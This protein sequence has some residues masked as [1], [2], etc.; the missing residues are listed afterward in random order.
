MHPLNSIDLVQIFTFKFMSIFKKK[1]KTIRFPSRT[2]KKTVESV[3]KNVIV[4]MGSS[5]LPKECEKSTVEGNSFFSH[6]HPS[7]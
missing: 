1:E 4:G 5:S 6:L 2:V 3:V 7:M